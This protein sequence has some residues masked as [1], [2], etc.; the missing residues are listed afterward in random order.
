MSTQETGLDWITFSTSHQLGWIECTRN[1]LD[2]KYLKV[3]ITQQRNPQIKFQVWNPQ[4]CY[5]LKISFKNDQ[6]CCFSPLQFKIFPCSVVLQSQH[7]EYSLQL[8]S[9]IMSTFL[10]KKKKILYFSLPLNY[11]WVLYRGFYSTSEHGKILKY[12][13]LRQD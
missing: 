2:L 8:L 4:T 10:N 1:I 9:N 12:K 13:G 3:N 7:Y 11:H 6:S 5:R